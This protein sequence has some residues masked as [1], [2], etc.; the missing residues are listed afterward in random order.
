M[1]IK[2]ENTISGPTATITLPNGTLFQFVGLRGAGVM[3]GVKPAQTGQ[4]S[5]A[6]MVTD[7][8]R[9]G[10]WETVK[11]MRAWAERFEADAESS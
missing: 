4:W 2:V 10:E 9:F 3:M 5:P 11:Q 6:H 8:E 7:P 1:S